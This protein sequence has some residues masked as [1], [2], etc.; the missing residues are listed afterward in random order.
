MLAVAHQAVVL[1]GGLGTRL[2]PLT[3]DL[4]KPMIAFHGRPFLEHL[5]VMLR[6]AGIQRVLL[7]VGYRA[8]KIVDHFGDGSRFGLPIA[9]SF[10]PVDNETGTRLRRAKPQID[11]F[12]LLLY[13][14][15]VWPFDLG[16]LTS[17]YRRQRRR[18]VTTVYAND[19]NWTCHNLRVG[20][21]GGVTQYDRSR[22]EPGLHGVDIGF[23]L[24]DRS[25]LDLLPVED[26]VSF[27]ATVYPKLI[28]AGDLGAL[29]TQHRYYSVGSL[30]RLPETEEFLLHRK[31]VLLD[32]DG[33]LNERMPPGQYVT[34][35]SQFTWKAGALDGLRALARADY[36]TAIVTN[37]AGVARGVLEECELRAIHEKMMMDALA[38]GGRI[39]ALFVCTHGWDDGCACR[40]PRPGLLFQAQRELRLDL[41]QT[42]FIGDD[43][44]DGE[45]AREAGARF[46]RL[47][48]GRGTILDAIATV[49]N[50]ERQFASA[51]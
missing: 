9:Y 17:E 42:T 25:V 43:E 4:P 13:C 12:F 21:D 1:A 19:D 6:D 7:L 31:T 22:S 35:S 48:D 37:Q 23:G 5:I 15:N 40:K 18:A 27:E 51:F 41:S 29:E 44:R 45:A 33:T 34:N 20:P 32:R 14:D 39:D 28:A 49:I 8:E 30:E 24:F 38:A 11:P 46:L 47:G 10:G 50:G 36:R 3:N 16:R 2:R 26:N